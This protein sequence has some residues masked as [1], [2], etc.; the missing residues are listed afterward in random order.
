MILKY[1]FSL[2]QLHLGGVNITQN[3][4]ANLAIATDIALHRQPHDQKKH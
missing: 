3:I 1:N 4:P 2:L